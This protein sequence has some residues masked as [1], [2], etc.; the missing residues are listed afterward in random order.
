MRSKKSACKGAALKVV[1]YPL[2]FLLFAFM[3]GCVHPQ[4]ELI[5]K[6]D[7]F[8]NGMRIT[9][10]QAGLQAGATPWGAKRIADTAVAR[11]EKEFREMEAEWRAWTQLEIF[12]HC[13][14]Y[15]LFPEMKEAAN[16]VDIIF[17]HFP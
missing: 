12:Y 8:H 3:L 1:G 13:L 7:V 6:I 11:W 4:V 9:L 14:A 17:L 15:Y 5:E 16:P 10:T 2:A